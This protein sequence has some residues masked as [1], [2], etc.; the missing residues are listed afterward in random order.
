MKSIETFFFLIKIING[1]EDEIDL[2]MLFYL[3]I[4]LYDRIECD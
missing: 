2:I 4:E 1:F 3:I